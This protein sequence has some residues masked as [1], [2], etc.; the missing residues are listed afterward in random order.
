MT[1]L[2]QAGDTNFFIVA[3]LNIAIHEDLGVGIELL[4]DIKITNNSSEIRKLLNPFLKESIGGLEYK[5]LISANAILYSVDSH[6][7]RF[8]PGSNPP[9]VRL[10]R[11]LQLCRN[12]LL[13]SWLIKDNS[14]N[15]E[16]GFI[17]YS[18]DNTINVSSNFLGSIFTNATG[19]RTPIELTLD[20]LKK[21]EQLF[22]KSIFNLL[23]QKPNQK[24]ANR[25]S[26]ALKYLDSARTSFELGLKV[27]FYCMCFESLF[28]TDSTELSHKIAERIAFFLSDD[29]EL[30]IGIYRN[31]KSAYGVRSKVVH[32]D[33]IPA[34]N[35]E[36]VH[37]VAL[38]CD[39]ALRQIMNKIF[40]SEN[41]TKV[42][43]SDNNTLENFLIGFTFGIRQN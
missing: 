39:Q 29:P 24:G 28:S 31:I 13:S 33:N 23:F 35:M 6:L 16:Q 11:I 2:V 19:E 18:L 30:R 7:I 17:Q 12:A 9:Q 4:P 15:F 3:L 8:E 14:I 5:S 41:Y 42:F 27:S 1:K 25:L 26:M 20:E 38:S 40:G 22:A 34:K 21:W 36:K 37:Q 10:E 32:G 43:T